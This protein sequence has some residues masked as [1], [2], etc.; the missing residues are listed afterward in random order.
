NQWC[1]QK[2]FTWFIPGK[3]PIR[4]STVHRPVV[5]DDATGRPACPPYDGKH[6]HQAVFEFWPTEL[7]QVFID[8]GIPRRKPPSM[9][10]CAMA[11]ERDGDPP[12]IVSPVRGAAYVMRLSR[13]DASR[14][15]FTASADADARLIYWFVDDAFVGS[16]AP[17][18][19]FYWQPTA[20]GHFRLRAVDDQGR[21]DERPLEID[22]D[23]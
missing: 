2:G 17:G 3:S 11:G 6:V 15:A 14:I 5:I 19:A 1:P 16:G 22:M 8:A 13:P 10:N 9:P 20:A 23:E 7:Q 4:V 18:T 21:S 12:L